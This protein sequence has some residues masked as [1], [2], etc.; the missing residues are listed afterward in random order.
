MARPAGLEP[1]TPGLEGEIRMPE[2]ARV[3]RLTMGAMPRCHAVKPEAAL[4]SSAYSQ[5][6]AFATGFWLTPVSIRFWTGNPTVR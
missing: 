6:A 2:V 4:A 1:A 5:R 3:Q